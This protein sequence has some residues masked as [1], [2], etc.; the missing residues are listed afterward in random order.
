MKFR[1]YYYRYT[2]SLTPIHRRYAVPMRTVAGNTRCK[3]HKYGT[4]PYKVYDALPGGGR[5]PRTYIL[6]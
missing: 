2:P 3:Y 5:R 4:P 6:Y 1:Y